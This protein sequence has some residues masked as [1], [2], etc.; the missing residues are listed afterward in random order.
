MYV[1]IQTFLLEGFLDNMFVIK[2]FLLIQETDRKTT[3]YD[4][5]TSRTTW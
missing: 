2:K 4:L 3:W 1:K 5:E